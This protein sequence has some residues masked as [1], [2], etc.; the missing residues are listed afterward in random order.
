M[1]FLEVKASTI[2]AVPNSRFILGSVLEDMP[3]MAV[4]IAASDL[5]PH[6]PV[7]IILN[8]CYLGL[9]ELVIE[10]R[11]PAPTIVFVVRS[12]KRLRA[13]DAV[14]HSGRISLVILI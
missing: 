10:C 5:S 9:F 11:P 6:H 13:D 7:T 2:N 8:F 12:E 1:L 4:T 3:Q 14:V